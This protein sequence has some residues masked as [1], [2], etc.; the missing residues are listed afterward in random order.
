MKLI[1]VSLLIARGHLAVTFRMIV[2][3]PL[4]NESRNDAVDAKVEG[5]VVCDDSSYRSGGLGQLLKRP[6]EQSKS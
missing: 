6:Q 3:L 2:S 1:H 5:S 4:S